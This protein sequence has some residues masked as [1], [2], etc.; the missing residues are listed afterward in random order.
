MVCPPIM[1]CW[2]LTVKARFSPVLPPTLPPS[3]SLSLSHSA[4]LNVGG[5]TEHDSSALL[6][7]DLK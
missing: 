4:R 7:V 2:C 1:Y 6:N 3:L 5:C